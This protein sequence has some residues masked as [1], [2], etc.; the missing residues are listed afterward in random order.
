MP[1]TL[2]RLGQHQTAS[3]ACKLQN[4]YTAAWWSCPDMS[5]F[6][7]IS[8]PEQEGT[9]RYISTVS[10]NESM[11]RSPG[12]IE[13]M[14]DNWVC[15]L[16]GCCCTESTSKRPGKQQRCWATKARHKSGRWCSKQSGQ[17]Q[18]ESVKQKPGSIKTTIPL[19]IP[20]NINKPPACE[21]M[22]PQIW[23]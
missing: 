11:K 18:T 19:N 15:S 23:S 7:S 20:T 13:H 2:P 14:Q 3:S 5:R 4:Q 10:R 22:I 9:T 21:L 1:S 17:C 8:A 12:R 16:Q 6:L